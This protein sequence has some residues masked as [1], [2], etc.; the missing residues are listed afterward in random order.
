MSS[1]DIYFQNNAYI[2]KVPYYVDEKRKFYTKSYSIKKYGTK[3]NAFECA[4]RKRDEIRMQI[5]TKSFILPSK[6]HSM[7]T[8]DDIMT[9]KEKLLPHSADTEKK[10]RIWQRN[11]MKIDKNFIYI[12]SADIQESLNKMI[13]KC[14]QTTIDRVL[15]LWKMLYK[16]CAIAD[17][18]IKDQT[19]KVYAPKSLVLTKK[20]A[21]MH[22]Y[23]SLDELFDTLNK[24]RVKSRDKQIL[25]EAIKVTYALGT[26]P[27][28]TF[29]LESKDINVKN[30]TVSI[31]KWMS[32]DGELKRTKTTDSYRS[33]PYTEADKEFFEKL[34]KRDGF[35]FRRDDGHLMCSNVA[36]NILNR[37]T[38]GRFR[39]YMMRHQLATDL[40]SGGADLKTTQKILGHKSAQ[41]TLKYAEPKDEDM[42]NAIEN[43]RK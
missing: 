43:V 39:M 10:H 7:D 23:S 8:I 11:Y 41:M 18:D 34:S 9:L 16:V 6:S 4:K 31:N 20:R 1:S 17:F 27:G 33:V 14:S 42:R 12:T 28:E 30:M 3:K 36:G 40:V 35:L 5:N 29:A 15:S 22:D 32:A 21:V 38:K 13:H 37:V 2:V 19:L 26:R 25:I 24:T